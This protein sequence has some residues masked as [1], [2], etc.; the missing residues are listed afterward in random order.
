MIANLLREAFAAMMANKMRTFLT[1]LGMVIGVA[2][3]ILMLAI[4]K[5]AQLVVQMTIAT[6]GSNLFVIDSG[7]RTSVGVRSTGNAPTLNLEDAHAIGE[8]P[9]VAA[10]APV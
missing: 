5:G 10:V 3:V 2:A 1:M 7:A 8:L 4:G 6:M 9:S